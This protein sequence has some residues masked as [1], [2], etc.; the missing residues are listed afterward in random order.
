M[1][2]PRRAGRY[3]AIG[4]R[5]VSDR[6]T[7]TGSYQLRAH[8]VQGHPIGAKAINLSRGKNGESYNHLSGC[9]FA[10]KAKCTVAG[11]SPSG[12][13]GKDDEE[14]E[15]EPRGTLNANQ[16]LLSV[17]ASVFRTEV[18][19]SCPQTDWSHKARS[20]ESPI[21]RSATSRCSKWQRDGTLCGAFEGEQRCN[22]ASSETNTVMVSL[23][24]ECRYK[25]ATVSF[26]SWYSLCWAGLCVARQSRTEAGTLQLCH[27]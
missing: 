25:W 4:A 11:S 12:S 15:L 17:P 20:N 18:A 5:S 21:S 10:W 7:N 22:S 2:P 26:Q 6:E 16:R 9:V 14:N 13:V 8:S 3:A 27:T 1:Q 19:S 23:S 24:L